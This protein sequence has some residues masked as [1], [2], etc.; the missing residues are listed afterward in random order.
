ME[1]V[2]EMKKI[3]FYVTILIFLNSTSVFADV[4]YCSE[5]DATGF[6]LKNNYKRMIY[7]QERFQ[8]KIDWQNKSMI[9]DKIYL[10][11]VKCDYNSISS[12]LYCMSRYGTTF[13]VNKKTLKFHKSSMFLESNSTDDIILS[14]GKC[15]KF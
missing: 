15:E 7:T 12:T 5:D 10:I 1:G 6:S 4:L 13:A 8:V 3:I 2:Y 9:S 11:N 14:H